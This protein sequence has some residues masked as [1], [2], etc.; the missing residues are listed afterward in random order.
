MST[1]GIERSARVLGQPSA[2]TI[3]RSDRTWGHGLDGEVR[4]ID[5]ALVCEFSAV[6]HPEFPE[7]EQHQAK[8]TEE[9]ADI[10]IARLESGTYDSYLAAVSSSGLRALLRINAPDTAHPLTVGPFVWRVTRLDDNGNQFVMRDSLS[11]EEATRIAQ[12]FE[13]RG[14]KQVYFV[15]RR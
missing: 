12:E 8:G 13:A 5:G 11:Y 9:L 6:C 1:V 3:R 7:F 10:V 2:V 14:H 4:G 15:E